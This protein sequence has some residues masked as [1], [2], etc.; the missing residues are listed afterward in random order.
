[1]ENKE[2]IIVNKIKKVVASY[3][4]ETDEIY[5]DAGRFGNVIK[6]KH[7]AMYFVRRN[8]RDITDKKIAK[9]FGF[10]SH[11][12]VISANKKISGFLDWD[13][14]IT[15]EFNDIQLKID[16]E[17]GLPTRMF[18]DLYILGRGVN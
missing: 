2:E 13:N 11:A 10:I 3:Y 8:I 5:E 4:G 17:L 7:A 16:E 6:I 15:K 14:K 1:M 12:T 18:I 9:L